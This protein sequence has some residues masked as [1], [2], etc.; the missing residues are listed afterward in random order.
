MMLL[1]SCGN[2]DRGVPKEES[3]EPNTLPAE[4]V[5]YREARETFLRWADAFSPT[6]DLEHAFPLLNA[7]SRRRLREQGVT[8]ARSFAD[9][10][11]RQASAQRPPFHY[12]FSRFDL[13]DIDMQD[14][15]RAVITATFLVH[16][17]QSS[18]ESVGSFILRRER[19]RW[20]VPF[21][22]GNSYESGWWEKEKNFAMRLTE[23]GLARLT[24]SRLSL[25]MRY[26]VAWDIVSRDRARIP[27]QQNALPGMEIQY[28]DP[29]TLSPI[30]FA[31][32]AILPGPLP[33]SLRVPPDSTAP[34]RLLRSE[35]ITND[36]GTAVDGE[37]RV[38]ADPSQDRFLLFYSG[39]DAAVA[40]YAR[41]AE[42]FAA[43]RKS[44]ASTSEVVP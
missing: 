5:L 14:T 38:L 43:M 19:G 15:N 6:P 11:L 27:T 33:D 32:I 44:L 1:A 10:F 22:S 20:T 18:F 17:H 12:T 31:R 7:A 37:L 25:S 30:A 4:V 2:E 34:L 39:V 13:L 28:I 42:T 29:A 41:F 35:R 36:L 23:E 21:V 9:W 16:I 3:G 26:P 40:E 24:S 8:D